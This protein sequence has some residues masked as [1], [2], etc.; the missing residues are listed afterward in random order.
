MK[1]PLKNARH[2]TFAHLVA[3]GRD[4]SAAYKEAGYSA[5]GNVAETNACR[6]LRNAQNGTPSR[7]RQRIDYLITE[8]RAES[9]KAATK[10]KEEKLA[11]LEELAWAKDVRASDVIS[12][13]RAHNE[14]TGDNAPTKII[15]EDGPERCIASARERALTIASP[16]NRLANSK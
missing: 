9:K 13:I 10:T 2:E 11:R 5:R 16:L 12:A 7:V 1:E 4:A 3:D 15:N 14:M 8:S 6:L